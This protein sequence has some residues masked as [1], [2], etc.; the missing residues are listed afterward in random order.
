MNSYFHKE[1]LSPLCN[2]LFLKLSVTVPN[3]GLE[4][5]NFNGSNLLLISKKFNPASL[6][7]NN[8]HL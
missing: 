4:G 3:Y 7:S 6:Y 2:N 1:V 5:N 8:N